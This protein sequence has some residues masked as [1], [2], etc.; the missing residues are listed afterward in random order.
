MLLIINVCIIAFICGIPLISTIKNGNF[1]KG[2]L[3][4]WKI[5]IIWGVLWLILPLIFLYFGQEEFVKR[6]FPEMIALP[7]V[8]SIFA[9]WINGCIVAGIGM[10]IHKVCK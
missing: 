6:Y 5:T 2:M 8:A 9:G 3:L 7:L 1:K 10:L 4:T